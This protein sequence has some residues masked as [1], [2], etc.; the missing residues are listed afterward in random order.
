MLI[1]HAAWQ[2]RLASELGGH[3][4]NQRNPDSAYSNSIRGPLPGAGAN[5][6]GE[7]KTTYRRY[8]N[9]PL[10]HDTRD[11]PVPVDGLMTISIRLK[12]NPV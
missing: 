7:R 9:L 1:E 4:E 6:S 8:V 5:F 3:S 2:A 10:F 11:E 12:G